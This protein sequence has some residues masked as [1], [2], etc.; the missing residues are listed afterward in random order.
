MPQSKVCARAWYGHGAKRA[1]ESVELGARERGSEGAR[2]QG[3]ERASDG[4][5]PTDFQSGGSER[6]SERPRAATVCCQRISKVEC[7]RVCVCVHVR[8]CSCLVKCC[9]L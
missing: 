8:V 5:L 6:A 7:V 3:S 9:S 1:R 4:L 2:E